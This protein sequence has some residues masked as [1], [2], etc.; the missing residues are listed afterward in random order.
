MQSPEHSVLCT[1][2]RDDDSSLRRHC[3]SVRRLSVQ[4]EDEITDFHVIERGS[5]LSHYV[6]RGA[7]GGDIV[8]PLIVNSM[9]V[10]FSGTSF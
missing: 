2:S 4:E 10:K 7:K 6:S 9:T 8:H 1:S 5:P 3:D